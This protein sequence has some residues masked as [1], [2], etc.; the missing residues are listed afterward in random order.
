[1]LQQIFTICTC[2]EKKNPKDPEI[3]KNAN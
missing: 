3:T 1:M 2:F